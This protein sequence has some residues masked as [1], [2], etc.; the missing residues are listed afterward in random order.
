MPD[1]SSIQHEKDNYSVSI[2][3]LMDLFLETGEPFPNEDS[4]PDSVWAI[5]ENR[6]KNAHDEEAKNISDFKKTWS[7]RDL[8]FD[9]WAGEEYGQRCLVSNSMYAALIVSIWAKTEEFLNDVV[10][11]IQRQK[12][13][14]GIKDEDKEYR[15]KNLH[16]AFK[17]CGINIYEC[18]NYDVVN[19]VR[20]VNNS[21]KHKNGIYVEQKQK[22][23]DKIDG[24][25][26]KDWEKINILKKLSASNKKGYSVSEEDRYEIDYTRLSIQKIIPKFNSF[27]RDLLGKARKNKKTV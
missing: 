15:I 18:V 12:A 10:R 4:F 1:N 6:I 27:C 26:K 24:S 22:N 2:I 11:D 9:D 23:H 20:I 5:W 14:E 21:F 8:D 16:C 7:D 13:G 25:L 17:Q 19:A 3:D